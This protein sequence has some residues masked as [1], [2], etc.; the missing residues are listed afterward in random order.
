MDGFPLD[1][2]RLVPAERW[3]LTR[4]GRRRLSRMEPTTL[5]SFAH[6]FHICTG[7][8][9]A[10]RDAL[11]A[12]G[13]FGT[14]LPN[15]EDDDMFIRLLAQGPVEYVDEPVLAYRVRG[16]SATA[17]WR[18]VEH[19]THLVYQRYIRSPLLTDHQRRALQRGYCCDVRRAAWKR[20]KA[21]RRA[22]RYGHWKPLGQS[23]VHLARLMGRLPAAEWR[24]MF[25]PAVAD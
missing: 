5:E 22:A 10:R 17:D 19:Y 1:R 13:E 24:C 7:V 14:D 15:S 20:L 9:L 12:C 25:L 8:M 11:A 6:R 21:I 23:L 16:A 4:I 18:S 2:T 3:T